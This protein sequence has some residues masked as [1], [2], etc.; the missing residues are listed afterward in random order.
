MTFMENA[1][2]SRFPFAERD[3]RYI[4]FSNGLLDI[5]EGELVDNVVNVLPR[6]YIDQPFLGVDD[7]ETP[8][9]DRLVRH[10]LKDDDVYTYMLGLIGRLLYDVRQFDV[11]PVIV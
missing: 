8:L 10:Q 9:F 6:H 1:N 7:V 2:D 4:G 11:V 3:R 5:V